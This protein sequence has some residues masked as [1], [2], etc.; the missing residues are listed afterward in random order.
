MKSVSPKLFGVLGLLGSIMY[1]QKRVYS[2]IKKG[3][4][5]VSQK[6]HHLA[7]PL[8]DLQIDDVALNKACLEILP[9]VMTSSFRL[10]LAELKFTD[11]S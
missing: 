10:C 5:N 6:R 7:V 11:A 4:K 3:R 9:I 2:R 8:L 1:F